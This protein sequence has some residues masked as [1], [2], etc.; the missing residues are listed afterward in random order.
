[1]Q[2]FSGNGR[3]MRS[4]GTFSNLYMRVT[5]NA[6]TGS[7]VVDFRIN[8]VDTLILLTVPATTTGEFEGTDSASVAAGDEVRIDLDH[9][10][11]TNAI[12]FSAVNILF[13][14]TTN[15]VCVPLMCNSGS[16]STNNTN[17]FYPIAGFGGG[18]GD[19][20]E[21]NSQY[22]AKTAGTAKNLFVNVDT[23]SRSQATT[24][25]LRKG[26]ASTALTIS[27]TASTTGF[28]EDTAN[29]DSVAVD[30]LINYRIRT[31]G[32]TGSI[33]VSHFSV[34]FETTNTAWPLI[35]GE[36]LGHALATSTTY[37]YTVGGGFFQSTTEL[38]TR[39]D[40]D[41]AFTW[42]KLTAY[43]SANGITATTTVRNRING[44]N[45]NQSLSIGSG[46]TGNFEDASNTDSV[47]ASDEMN[48]SIVTGGT[49]T[50][51]TLNQLASLGQITVSAAARK[52][53]MTLLGVGI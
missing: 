6:V 40:A 35:G 10:D 22:K 1:M 14:A 19:S 16:L 41:V 44:A 43:V 49:G 24:A 27:I 51:L 46:A 25:D 4:A 17:F 8:L 31:A 15:T 3:T 29:T 11:L 36:T 28:F 21:A 42:S 50:T 7:S 53:S 45:G 9:G 18:G 48:Y 52:P 47:V 26:A 5:A 20:T 34:E 39:A 2:T 30:A 13:A 23:N 38:N 12:T 32:G 33:R 37:F